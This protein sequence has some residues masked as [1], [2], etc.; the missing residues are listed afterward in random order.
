M[1][2]G[3][4]QIT[5]FWA[6]P[7]IKNYEVIKT[8]KGTSLEGQNLSG[9][10]LLVCCDLNL[11][12]EYLDDEENSISTGYHKTPFYIDV[13]LPET[14]NIH[15]PVKVTLCIDDILAENLDSKSIYNNTSMVV[16]VDI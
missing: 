10:K 8:P 4:S 5:K 11:K 12:F 3:I 9:Y 6:N 2:L 13:I 16:V 7:S 15:S 1:D 14:F